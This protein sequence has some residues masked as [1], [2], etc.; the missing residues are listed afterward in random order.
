M[1][2]GSN[3]MSRLDRPS[4]DENCT[5]LDPRL[6]NRSGYLNTYR[7]EGP[8]KEPVQPITGTIRRNNYLELLRI[9]FL[10]AITHIAT[11]TP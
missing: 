7:G 5:F 9:A 3:C 8:G 11:L 4:L 10:S 6:Q 1:F 2:P